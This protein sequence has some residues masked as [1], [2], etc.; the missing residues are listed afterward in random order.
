MV[1]ALVMRS[2]IYDL[3]T[4]GSLDLMPTSLLLMQHFM[5]TK[6]KSY[7]GIYILD[8]LAVTRANTHCAYSE[9]VNKTIGGRFKAVPE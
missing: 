9:V 4:V 7:G 2:T 1:N 8:A 5:L 6:S 3:A